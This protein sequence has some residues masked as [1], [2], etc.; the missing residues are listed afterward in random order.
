MSNPMLLCM[1]II[2]GI[3]TDS[4]S[5]SPYGFGYDIDTYILSSDD[6]I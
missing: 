4:D 5:D 3:S 6:E 1:E 2:S